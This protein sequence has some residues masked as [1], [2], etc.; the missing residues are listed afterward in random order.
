[1]TLLGQQAER[2]ERILGYQLIGKYETTQGDSVR[3]YVVQIQR[4]DERRGVRT[5]SRLDQTG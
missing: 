1:V 3:F 4:G 5:R 2:G